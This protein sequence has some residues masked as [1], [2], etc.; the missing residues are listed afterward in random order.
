MYCTLATWEE[1]ESCN[2]KFSTR[3][4]PTLNL[5]RKVSARTTSLLLPLYPYRLCHLFWMS[6]DLSKSLWPSRSRQGY[7]MTKQ[8]LSAQARMRNNLRIF[9]VV[10]PSTPPGNGYVSPK[11]KQLSQKHSQ[12]NRTYHFNPVPSVIQTIKLSQLWWNLIDVM[13]I[14]P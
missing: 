13:A 11:L 7:G 6:S 9:S 2:S 3:P 4:K 14:K 8:P 1:A 12:S 5:P 10:R